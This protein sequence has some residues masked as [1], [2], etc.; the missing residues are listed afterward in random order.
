MRL[1]LSYSALIYS[2]SSEPEPPMAGLN[3]SSPKVLINL[4]NWASYAGE[5]LSHISTGS[6]PDKPQAK[7]SLSRGRGKLISVVIVT[8]L[9]AMLNRSVSH[10]HQSLQQKAYAVLKKS[11]KKVSLRAFAAA[12]AKGGKP[13]TK[14][15]TIAPDRPPIRRGG[16]GRSATAYRLCPRP[17]SRSA[18][19]SRSFSISR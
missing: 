12:C 14:R 11:V 13:K 6:G 19:L 15:E 7:G 17:R 2:P 9:T 3:P 16:R 18:M 8:C 5:N 4:S 10:P 1:F